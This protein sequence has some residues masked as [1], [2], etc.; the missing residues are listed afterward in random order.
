MLAVLTEI[1]LLIWVF[2]GSSPYHQPIFNTVGLTIL[3]MI[4]SGVLGGWIRSGSR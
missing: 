3:V 2:Q 4:I 1:T